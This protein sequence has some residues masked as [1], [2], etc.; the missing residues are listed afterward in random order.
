MKIP[1][2]PGTASLI[3]KFSDYRLEWR[4][5]NGTLNKVLLTFII[6]LALIIRIK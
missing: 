5:S 4:T 2:I 1:L 6:A 3:F